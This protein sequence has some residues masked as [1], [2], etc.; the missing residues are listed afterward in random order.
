VV[1]VEDPQA[2]DY[3]REVQPV[4][5]R[6]LNAGAASVALDL[7]HPLGRDAFLRMLPEV[8]VVLEGFRPGVLE[9]LGLGFPELHAANPR[10]VLTSISG[11][12][13]DSGL[14]DR[15]GHDVNYLARS[16]ILSLMGEIP[17]VQL[18]DLSGG[19]LAA[20]A[21]LAAVVGARTTGVGTHVE[22]PLADSV[23][24]LGVLLAAE[25]ATQRET[26]LLA[27]GLP[28][29]SLYV[30]ADGQRVALGALEAKFWTRFCQA[31]GRPDWTERQF[32][33]SLKNEVAAL[34]AARPAAE[35]GALGAAADCCLEKVEAM[36]EAARAGHHDRPVRFGDARPAAEG[37]APDRGAQT[38]QFLRQVGF[39][40]QEIHTMAAEGVILSE[41]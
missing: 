32:D 33:P 7:K 14:A 28:C 41:R 3:L 34:F 39:S 4:W 6:A 24:A 38:Q 36:P 21:T 12:A 8:D 15:A 35:W 1:K 16:G 5:F 20:G 37:T 23:A 17:P 18:A 40:E 26:L 22:V 30:A 2:G 29:Y 11:Y 31:A 27:G 25:G 10:L 13:S 9:R 19:M